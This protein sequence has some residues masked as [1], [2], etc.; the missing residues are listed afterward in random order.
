[1]RAS[2]DRSQSSMGNNLQQ[3]PS[4]NNDGDGGGIVSPHTD[5]LTPSRL[6]DSLPAGDGAAPFSC[7]EGYLLGSFMPGVADFSTPGFDDVY[8]YS[9]EVQDWGLYQD[10][11][12]Y[13]CAV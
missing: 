13:G 9:G 1:M 3:P 5:S 6:F 2:L 11:V 10:G 12:D 7:I 4:R 8:R